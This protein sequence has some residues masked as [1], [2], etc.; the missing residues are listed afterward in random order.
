VNRPCFLSL[1]GPDCARFGLEYA[2][3]AESMPQQIFKT[4]TYDHAL[5]L[6]WALASSAAAAVLMY[7]PAKIIASIT[8]SEFLMFEILFFW[9]SGVFFFAFDIL[10]V[11]FRRQCYLPVYQFSLRRAMLAIFAVAVILALNLLPTDDV[12]NGRVTNNPDYTVINTRTYG[13]PASV[14][15]FRTYQSGKRES[16]WSEINGI[17]VC[18]DVFYGISAIAFILSFGNAIPKSK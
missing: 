10:H 2:R 16:S 5:V 18:F 6:K 9:M 7:F 12:G 11:L 15:A 13:W 4:K 1:H 17:L 14:I 8:Q 3:R